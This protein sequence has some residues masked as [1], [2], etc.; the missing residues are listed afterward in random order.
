[1]GVT[2]GGILEKVPSSLKRKLQISMVITRIL[3]EVGEGN[4]GTDTCPDNLPSYG[5][6]LFVTIATT[7]LTFKGHCSPSVL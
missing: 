7:V 4:A 6:P 3:L 5:G 1:M 2:C